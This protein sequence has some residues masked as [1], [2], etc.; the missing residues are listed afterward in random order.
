MDVNDYKHIPLLICSTP[1]QMLQ[2]SS[3]R[4]Q[5]YSRH[6]QM[7]RK[8]PALS[9]GVQTHTNTKNIMNQ[10]HIAIIKCPASLHI[11]RQRI[12]RILQFKARPSAAQP[13]PFIISVCRPSACIHEKNARMRAA[14][15]RGPIIFCSHFASLRHNTAKNRVRLSV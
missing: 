7:K 5:K 13:L 10:L 15:T 9:P 6:K 8:F 3:C 14:I 1:I 12:L 11:N 4:S 2:M